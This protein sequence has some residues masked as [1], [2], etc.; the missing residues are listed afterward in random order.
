MFSD[1][2]EP[3]HDRL[4]RTFAQ[5]A[6]HA[7][8]DHSPLYARLAAGIAGDSE[9][10]ALAARAQPG[11]PVPNLLFAAAHYLLL[12]GARHP[13][14][15]FYPSITPS[16]ENPGTNQDPYPAFR[17]FCVEQS[18]AIRALIGARLVQTNE[19]RRCACLLPAFG[20]VARRAPGRPLALIEIGASAGLNLLWDRYG[21]DYG[22]GRRYGDATSPVQLTCAPR[23]NRRP[24]LSATLPPVAWRVGLDLHPADVRDPDAALW[25]RALI[26][27]EHAQRAEALQ[28]AMRLACGDPPRLVAGD[29][30]A[31]LP[32]ALAETPREAVLCVYHSWTLNQFA[33]ESRATL[34]MLLAAHA[35]QRDV[36]RI[37]IEH[38]DAQGLD[39]TLALTTYAKGAT[40]EDVLA[41]CQSHGEW[42][43]WLGPK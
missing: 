33:A 31:T 12:R 6:V 40:T 32:Q 17:A 4:A 5:F 24:P 10:L 26:W 34:T 20:L 7:G 27:P 19:V 28:E 42:L 38:V 1:A 13:V 30:L 18:A 2:A 35:A 9:L 22:G 29:A 25:L 43:E 11:Q 39:P 16:A 36:F 8:H 15:A 41:R 21:Y 23:G 3:P 14:A 37:S